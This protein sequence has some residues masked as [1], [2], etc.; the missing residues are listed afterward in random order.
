MYSFYDY[1][2]V[3]GMPQMKAGGDPDG[4]MAMGQIMAMHEKLSALQKFIRPDS[5]LEPWVASKLTLANDYLNS[6]SEYMQYNPEESEEMEYEEGLPTEQM[7]RGGGSTFSGNAWYQGG[8]EPRTFWQTASQFVPGYETYLDIKDIVAGAAKGNKAQMNQ[9]VIG[10]GQPFAG[11]AISGGLD[12]LTE[13]LFGKQ[14][15]DEISTKREGI[16]NMTDRERQ[17]LFKR[18][19]YGGYDKWVKAGKPKL[20]DGGIHINPVNKGKFTASAQAAGMGVQ[21]FASHVL[22]NK[23]DY[24]STQVKRANFARNASKWKH[25]DGGPIEG[26]VLDVTP[27]Q[28]QYLRQMGYDFETI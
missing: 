27:E 7:M 16:V 2:Q 28:A 11:K 6:V 14:V 26:D 5:D 13:K 3:G 8:G 19:G 20:E 15:A 24:S 10:L 25:Q 23:E 18:Y 21:E 4:E 12:Y 9:G 1:M 22:A 17:E